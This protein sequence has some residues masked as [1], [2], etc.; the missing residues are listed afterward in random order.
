MQP[1][2]VVRSGVLRVGDNVNRVAVRV[3]DRGAGD[4]YL[5]DGAVNV[6]PVDVSFTAGQKV[7][8]PQ[9]G[10]GIGVEGV[11]A[12]VGGGD[13]HHVVLGGINSEAAHV[14]RLSPDVAVDS[15][16]EEHA[17]GA[18]VHVGRSQYRLLSLPS[19]AQVVV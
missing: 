16:A 3:D 7:L 18:A 1:M 14:Q 11:R 5:G 6:A 17:E 15:G 9:L 8:H 10:A 12:V 19:A 4:A 13:I 2:E